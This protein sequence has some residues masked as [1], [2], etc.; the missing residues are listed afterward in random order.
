[1]VVV[2]AAA[3]ARVVHN[4]TRVPSS[5]FIDKKLSL[6]RQRETALQRYL[7]EWK[8]FYDKFEMVNGNE[9]VDV[10]YVYS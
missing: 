9:L 5:S 8:S 2:V 1:M 3:V 4:N 7:G 10:L 6:Q